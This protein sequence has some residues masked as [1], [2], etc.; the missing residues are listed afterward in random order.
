MTILL[1]EATWEDLRDLDRGR[2][3]AILPIGATEAHGPHLPL[4]TDVV[5][6]EAMASAAAARLGD[7]GIPVVILPSFAYTA[8]GFA[9]EFPGTISVSAS[10]VTALLLD[11]A[12]EL[13]RQGFRTLALANSHLDPEHLASLDAAVA[14]PDSERGLTIVFPNL[15]RKPWGGRLTDEFQSGAC[16]AGQFETSVVLAARPDL[17]REMAR[18]DLP[19]NPSSLSDAIRAGK[20][21]FLEANGPRAYF[22]APQAATSREGEATIEVL[23]EILASAVREALA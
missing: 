3:V 4:E 10:T 1:G 12:R 11:V 22:G 9:R 19:A 18:R 7:A 6:S 23:G 2:A 8:A 5:I 21:S 16:H 15:T 17:V 13:A 20:K 14:A